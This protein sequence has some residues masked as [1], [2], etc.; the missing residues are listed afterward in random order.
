[1][2][3]S[4]THPEEIVLATDFNSDFRKSEI[5]HLS[6]LARITNAR[7][8]VISQTGSTMLSPLQKKNKM[9]LRNYFREVEHSFNDRHYENV[10]DV[11]KSLVKGGYS[12]M[13]SYIDKKP[14]FWEQLGFG[15]PTLGKLGNFKDKP[16]LVLNERA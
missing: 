2:D 5:K 14:S 13:I 8:K 3:V 1:M 6:E 4:F 9:W 16:V 11:L 12:D 7:I 10:A 15:K